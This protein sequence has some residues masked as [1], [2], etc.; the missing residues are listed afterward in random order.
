MRSI[1]INPERMRSFCTPVCRFSI[2]DNVPA[3]LMPHLT[4]KSSSGLLSISSVLFCKTQLV[5]FAG[6]RGCSIAKCLG[7]PA[8]HFWLG[9]NNLSVRRLA[10]L[11]CPG[12]VRRNNSGGG[13]R[14]A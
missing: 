10:S 3:S 6:L 4:R 13:G 11:E 2:S 12:A 1:G 14:G 5:P 7:E 8:M 9:G